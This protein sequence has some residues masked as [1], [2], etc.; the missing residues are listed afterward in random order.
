VDKTQNYWVSGILQALWRM[1]HFGYWL[2]VHPQLEGGGT[3]SFGSLRKSKSESLDN[4]CLYNYTYEMPE[5]R[6]CVREITRKYVA[7][8]M[9]GPAQT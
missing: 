5:T 1:Q 6:L 7:T 9:I 8:I 3:Y 2:F 4:S